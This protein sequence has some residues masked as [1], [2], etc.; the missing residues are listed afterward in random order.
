MFAMHTSSDRGRCRRLAPVAPVWRS[1]HDRW[2]R[3]GLDRDPAHGLED[4]PPP[5]PYS[6]YIDSLINFAVGKPGCG[7]GKFLQDLAAFWRTNMS[8]TYP[9]CLTANI[10]DALTNCKYILATK[11]LFKAS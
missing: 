9:K 5:P 3:H 2:A 11:S 10:E 7:D 8:L 4:A 1:G 6:D